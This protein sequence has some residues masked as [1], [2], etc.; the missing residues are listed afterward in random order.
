MNTTVEDPAIHPRTPPRYLIRS[1]CESFFDPAFFVPFHGLVGLSHVPFR[2][3][4]SARN[5]L[6]PPRFRPLLLYVA[7]LICTT[8]NILAIYPKKYVHRG[9]DTGGPD[10]GSARCSGNAQKRL[11]AHDGSLRYSYNT[12]ILTMHATQES[13]GTRRK[14]RSGPGQ[15]RLPMRDGRKRERRLRL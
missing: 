10:R 11:V 14:L 9:S 3:S 13:N 4:I 7:S 12:S 8:T 1:S 5:F 6:R 15:I 2:V